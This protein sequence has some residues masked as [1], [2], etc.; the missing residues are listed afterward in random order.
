MRVNQNSNA[1]ESNNSK[2]PSLTSKANL[3]QCKNNNDSTTQN[4]IIKKT[5]TQT[6]DS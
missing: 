6:L 4:T 2:Y 5:S 1:E 3:Q